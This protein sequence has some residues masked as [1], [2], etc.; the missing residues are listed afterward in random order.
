MPLNFP[1]EK[2]LRKHTRRHW[3]E[4]NLPNNVATNDYLALARTFCEGDC[5]EGTDE[6]TRTCDNK[7]D[8]FCDATAYFAVMMPNRTAIITF[9]VLHPAG[10]VGITPNKM[11]AFATNREYFEADCECLSRI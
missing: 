10:T 8:R 6:C 9:H 5:P 2:E 7:I 3:Q 1:S 4:L 11:H